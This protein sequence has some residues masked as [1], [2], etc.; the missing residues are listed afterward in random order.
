MDILNIKIKKEKLKQSARD[1]VLFSASIDTL[2]DFVKAVDSIEENDQA[3]EFLDEMIK[4]FNEEKKD[5]MES[6]KNVLQKK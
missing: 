1:S 2:G 5:V 3:E 6:Y 4:R